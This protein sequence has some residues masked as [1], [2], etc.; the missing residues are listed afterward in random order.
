MFQSVL[1]RIIWQK[2]EDL[3]LRPC[4][5]FRNGVLIL[6]F[7]GVTIK[8]SLFTLTVIGVTLEKVIFLERTG[9]T[10][11]SGPF[12]T[13]PLKVTF[14]NHIFILI[15][16][17]LESVLRFLKLISVTPENFVFILTVSTRLPNTFFLKFV[18]AIFMKELFLFY[19]TGAALRNG[20]FFS[21]S[22]ASLLSKVLSFLLSSGKN[23]FF[24]K[25]IFHNL[26][27]QRP[28][29]FFYFKK[30]LFAHLIDLKPLEVCWKQIFVLPAYMKTLQ[31]PIWAQSVVLVSYD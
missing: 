26:L 19:L 23:A 20:Q 16:I 10:S 30:H 2:N 28:R 22:S 4:I 8:N 6:A 18:S 15:G 9:I 31:F 1:G 5:T 3:L 24:S 14:K 7:I 11:K 29:L 13:P 27:L 21:F 12:F 25:Y 17:T